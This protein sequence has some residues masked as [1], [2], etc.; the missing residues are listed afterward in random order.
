M[1]PSTEAN[2]PYY[3]QS[4][5]NSTFARYL[6]PDWL[7]TFPKSWLDQTYRSGLFGVTIWEGF[8]RWVVWLSLP[9]GKAIVDRVNMLPQIRLPK[10]LEYI[11]TQPIARLPLV[12]R[13]AYWFH[14]RVHRIFLSLGVWNLITTSL[15][16][17]FGPAWVFHWF[18]CY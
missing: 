18:D 8:G 15:I 9:N 3:Q 17:E 10:F 6:F 12:D 14:W 2:H 4:L 1:L 13:D 5:S 7:Y 16:Y 11:S